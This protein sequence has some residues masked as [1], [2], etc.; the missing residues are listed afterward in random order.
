MRQVDLEDLYPVFL[1][2]LLLDVPGANPGIGYIQQGLTIQVDEA[3]TNVVVRNLIGTLSYRNREQIVRLLHRMTGWWNEDENDRR[4]NLIDYWANIAGLHLEYRDTYYI[5][6]NRYERWRRYMHAMD[7]DLP[8][9]CHLLREHHGSIKNPDDL[10][11]RL[12]RWP[13][14]LRGD[15]P[16]LYR[17]LG[18]GMACLH[19]HLSGSYPSP[20]FWVA[21]MNNRFS[22][23]EIT[24]SVELASWQR[25][26]RDPEQIKAIG[27]MTTRARVTRFKLFTYLKEIGALGGPSNA[28]GAPTPSAATTR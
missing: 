14:F 4:L 5:R 10:S 15:E 11:H 6:A 3:L 1:T 23:D 28:Q 27:G 18:R 22:P 17:D 25:G 20:Y 2:K 19:L 12:E 7:E 9:L 8:A 21:L 16:Q 26:Y 24:K 13:T